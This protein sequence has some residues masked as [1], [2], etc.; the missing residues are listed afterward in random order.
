[1]PFLMPQSFQFFY[2]L[3]EYIILPNSLIQ[4][5]TFFKTSNFETM[6]QWYKCQKFCNNKCN[7]HK[8]LLRT[9]VAI[10]NASIIEICILK[11]IYQGLFKNQ[12]SQF[13]FFLTLPIVKQCFQNMYKH[14]KYIVCLIHKYLLFQICATCCWTRFEVSCIHSSMY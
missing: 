2:G 10:F 8:L 3:T 13:S 11:K 6:L 5:S 14:Q 12:A 4:I 9:F 7:K 1:M